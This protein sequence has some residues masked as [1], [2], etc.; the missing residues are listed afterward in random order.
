MFKTLDAAR[1]IETAERLHRRVGERFPE[2]S[3]AKVAGELLELA[4]AGRADIDALS[5]P[6]WWLRATVTGLTAAGAFL[7]VYVGSFIRIGGAGAIDVGALEAGINTL[8]LA[9]LGLLFL[10]RA[11]ARVKQARAL[12]ALHQYR[13]IAHVI[14]MHQM[15]KDPVMLGTDRPRTAASRRVTLTPF[16]ME[17]YLDY[18]SELLSVNAKIAALYA[19][20]IDDPVVVEAVSDIEAMCTGMARKVW[21]KIMILQAG[22][23]P[24]RVFGGGVG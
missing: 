6:I 3:L 2:S 7:F 12:K 21:Q 8:V 16:E 23:G 13:S 5:A 1:I 19:Q 11:E 20:H 4:R 9:G 15:G 22:H 24:G 10:A 14:D 17:R 18:C